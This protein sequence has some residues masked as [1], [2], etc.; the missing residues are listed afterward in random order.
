MDP[1][2]KHSDR[3]K[4]PWSIEEDELLCTLVD[5]YAA[6]NWTTISNS[7]S[8]RSGK[9]CRL[10]WCNQLS[11][12]IEHRP[13]TAEDDDVILHAHGRFGNRWATIARLLNGR[14]DNAVKNHWNSTLKRKCAA[15]VDG[16]GGDRQRPRISGPTDLGAGIGGSLSGSDLCESSGNDVPLPAITD[17]C[18][19]SPEIQTEPLTALTL[20]LPGTAGS[21][22]DDSCDRKSAKKGNATPF[23]EEMLS[24][25]QDMIRSEVKKYMACEEG[26]VR[27]AGAK[28]M[29]NHIK[30]DKN[31]KDM[32]TQPP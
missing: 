2:R 22:L 14:T 8:G 1:S 10:R 12:D 6:R 7:I 20:A 16:G 27:N 15:T 17:T 23:S 32:G 4:G 19:T 5:R 11:P 28:Q 3:I 30:V 26:S 24:M 21:Y 18:V 9:S 13:F 29:L 31:Y 25:M